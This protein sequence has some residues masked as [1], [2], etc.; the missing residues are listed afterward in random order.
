MRYLGCPSPRRLQYSSV[1]RSRGEVWGPIFE[2]V[3]FGCSKAFNRNMAWWRDRSPDKV[4]QTSRKKG[5]AIE[6]NV[7]NYL[8]LW[9]G[10][11]SHK[12]IPLFS[13]YHRKLQY[14]DMTLALNWTLYF[15]RT[16]FFLLGFI[17]KGHSTL[18]FS[19]KTFYLTGCP[20]ISSSMLFF[21]SLSHSSN[22]RLLLILYIP[23]VENSRPSW[24]VS[25]SDFFKNLTLAWE[26]H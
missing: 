2:G 10:D 16:K 22:W 12:E 14:K 6:L 17:M 23:S 24:E 11:R 26:E 19:G 9:K 20:V 3:R 4:G 1:W 21:L 15:I 13:F 8:N 25:R 7:H 18:S 5:K